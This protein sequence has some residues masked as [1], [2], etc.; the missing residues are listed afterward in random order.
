MNIFILCD[1]ANLMMPTAF[2]PNNDGLNDVFYPLS[3]GIR[4]INKFSIYNR[5]HKLIFERK[6]FEPNYRQMGWD[7]K[8][9][10]QLLDADTYIYAI[11]ATC[12]YG[13]LVTKTGTVIL[14]R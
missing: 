6:N 2:T 13:K 9:N 1:Q 3:K 12:N 4:I 8:S 10:Q 11:E 5:Y 14:I 7:G